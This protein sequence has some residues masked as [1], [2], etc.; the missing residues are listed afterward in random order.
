ML[1]LPML[2]QAGVRH[3]I[4]AV[5][6]PAAQAAA[7]MHDCCP[8]GDRDTGDGDMPCEAGDVIGC[9]NC[10][11][12]YSCHFPTQF[13]ISGPAAWPVPVSVADVSPAFLVRPP[14]RGS[15]DGLLRPPRIH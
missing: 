2:A 8:D 11:I 15:P 7:G 12:G 13:A 9:V 10:D 4:D 5:A 3:A 6:L 14:A 1:L